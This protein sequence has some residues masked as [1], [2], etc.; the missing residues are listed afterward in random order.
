[1][2]AE[3]VLDPE[4]FRLDA[5]EGA[6]ASGVGVVHLIPRLYAWCIR[7]GKRM[8]SAYVWSRGSAMKNRDV[9]DSAANKVGG[10]TALAKVLSWNKGS[11][12][13]IKKGTRPLPPWRA[14]QIA[15]I[16]EQDPKAAYLEALAAQAETDREREFLGKFLGGVRRGAKVLTLAF[17]LVSAGF[18][19]DEAVA[20]ASAEKGSE[21]TLWTFDVRRCAAILWRALHGV[22]HVLRSLGW[23]QRPRSE[24]ALA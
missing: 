3:G 13:A 16:M 22:L 18:Q 14:A 12:A 2:A 21:Y 8:R 23:W 20:S 10:I 19:S 5:E 1:M 4:M 15:E 24:A 11:I 6:A 17:A 9:I 7:R